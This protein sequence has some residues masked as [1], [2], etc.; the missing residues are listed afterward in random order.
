M[1]I[2][3]QLILLNLGIQ[4]NRRFNHLL[5]HMLQPLHIHLLEIAYAPDISSLDQAQEMQ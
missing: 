4:L 3:L 1:H 2:Q 5:P